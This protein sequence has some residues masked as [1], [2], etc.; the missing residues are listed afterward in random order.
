MWRTAKRRDAGGRV[1]TVSVTPGAGKRKKPAPEVPAPAMLTSLFANAV[2]RILR[3]GFH[4]CVALRA[5]DD[6]LPFA[7]G[8]REHRPAVGALEE[9]LRLA[10]LPHLLGG[11]RLALKLLGRTRAAARRAAPT[12]STAGAAEALPY[13]GKLGH[14][15]AKRGV[16][17]ISSISILGE[18][19]QEGN[20]EDGERDDRDGAQVEYGPNKRKHHTKRA[21]GA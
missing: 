14:H 5:G 7:A 20:D 11:A 1:V 21:E 16:L 6:D 19:A 18:G 12:V 9:G 17:A 15:V 4:A 8:N 2:L 13:D 3:F 10:F